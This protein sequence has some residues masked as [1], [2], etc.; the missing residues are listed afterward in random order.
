[1]RWK[2]DA[3]LLRKN[4]QFPPFVA[5]LLVCYRS[6][7][8]FIKK[9]SLRNKCRNSRLIR[10][11]GCDGDR[12]SLFWL[13]AKWEIFGR[14]APKLICGKANLTDIWRS[15]LMNDA[16]KVLIM[17]LFPIVLVMLQHE[18]GDQGRWR[19]RN[20]PISFYFLKIQSQVWR[21]RWMFDHCN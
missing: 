14:N 8:F 5:S 2:T 16:A 17:T 4:P 9:F 15:R 3:Q 13:C 11:L 21:E 7:L 12:S 10:T 6:G 19:G 18:R 1:M 20:V